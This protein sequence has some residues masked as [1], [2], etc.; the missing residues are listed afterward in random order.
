[1]RSRGRVVHLATRPSSEHDELF[2]FLDALRQVNQTV[3]IADRGVEQQLGISGAQL[4]VL[5]QLAQAPAT[6]LNE[7][8]AR[9]FTRHSSVSVVVSRL[10]EAGLVER[11]SSELDGRRITLEVTKAGRA[12]L[13]RAPQSAHAR[14]IAAARGLSRTKLGQLA[15]SL[16]Q[17]NQSLEGRE[18]KVSSR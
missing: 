16:E 6:S 11:N 14:L 9:T 13:R 17:V 12:L 7:L 3:R 18:A 15:E 8:A 1:M 5:E 4:F 2:A 10:V